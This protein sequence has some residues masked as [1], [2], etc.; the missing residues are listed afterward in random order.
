MS[1][2]LDVSRPLTRAVRHYPDRAEALREFCRENLGWGDVPKV[3]QARQFLER[4]GEPPRVAW[5]DDATE[6]DIALAFLAFDEKGMDAA[7][8]AKLSGPE[9]ADAAFGVRHEL[10]FQTLPKL[11]ERLG[12]ARF[13]GDFKGRAEIE[14]SDGADEFS[15]FPRRRTWRRRAEGAEVERLADELE[16]KFWKLDRARARFLN[17]WLAWAQERE[18]TIEK[19]RNHNE[20]RAGATR[21]ELTLKVG[22]PLTLKLGRRAPEAVLG[23]W[24]SQ[25][26]AETPLDSQLVQWCEAL[27]PQPRE[28]N[29]DAM[30]GEYRRLMNWSEIEIA[31]VDERAEVLLEAA[32]NTI[33]AGKDPLFEYGSP[34]RLWSSHLWYRGPR[35]AWADDEFWLGLKSRHEFDDDSLW[36]ALRGDEAEEKRLRDAVTHPN[37]ENYWWESFGNFFLLYFRAELAFAIDDWDNESSSPANTLPHPVFP[38]PPDISAKRADA[39]RLELQEWERQPTAENAEEL[40]ELAARLD[41][42]A[43]A[44]W[45]HERDL[46]VLKTAFA[47][48]ARGRDESVYFDDLWVAVA[49]FEWSD[50]AE[51]VERSPQTAANLEAHDD[52]YWENFLLGASLVRPSRFVAQ[53]SAS[54]LTERAFAPFSDADAIKHGAQQFREAFKKQHHLAAAVAWKRCRAAGIGEREA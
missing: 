12:A 50:I 21:H 5:K 33:E 34:L 45:L 44:N 39:L 30:P 6:P 54:F 37:V 8:E 25:N 43:V 38:L 31:Q 46:T 35:D 14:F 29:L 27:A 23:Q 40:V 19:T 17:G 36:R 3:E 42:W 1:S 49:L 48:L 22:R 11:I 16:G 28:A 4:E 24:I 41:R 18:L 10:G 51:L 47:S 32:R 7:A 26:T 20:W 2:S 9:V 15:I 52:T 13:F 53:L